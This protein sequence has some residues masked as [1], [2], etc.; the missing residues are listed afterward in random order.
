MVNWALQWRS[1]RDPELPRECEGGGTQWGV[2]FS[3][4]EARE[5]QRS[6]HSETA[7][8]HPSLENRWQSLDP[9]LAALWGRGH[10]RVISR[11]RRF[12][13]H[14]RVLFRLGT[15]PPR[16]RSSSL[17]VPLSLVCQDWLLEP[18]GKKEASSQFLY[19]YELFEYGCFMGFLLSPPCPSES[20]FP[21]SNF[22]HF[23][24]QIIL[25]WARPQDP[26]LCLEGP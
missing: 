15:P 1:A 19:L 21:Q 4:L 13:Y 20:S 16:A 3:W 12:N 24:A 22:I 5:T 14:C 23:S 25:L 10:S 9:F 8:L 26:P 17:R 7:S 2:L 6:G 11:R 18:Q